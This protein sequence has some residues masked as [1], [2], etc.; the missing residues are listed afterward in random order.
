[1]KS[2]EE[3]TVAAVVVD[4]VARREGVELEVQE[5]ERVEKR[6]EVGDTVPVKVLV[7]VGGG[8]VMVV[9]LV[10]VTEGLLVSITVRVGEGVIVWDREGAS[11]GVTE[12]QAVEVSEMEGERLSD[13]E[14][15]EEALVLGVTLVEPE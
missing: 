5:A 4:G 15:V 1:M 6:E 9:V 11:E 7:I 14:G 3:V 10:L 8:S 12:G 2:A 13:A